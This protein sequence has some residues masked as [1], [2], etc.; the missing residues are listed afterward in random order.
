MTYC[1]VDRRHGRVYDDVSSRPGRWWCGH[2]AHGGNGRFFTTAEVEGG[3]ERTEEDMTLIYETAARDVVDGTIDLDMAVKKIASQ[4][5]ERTDRVRERLNTMATIV[6]DKRAAAAKRTATSKPK[7]KPARAERVKKEHVEPRE[8]A[9]VRD[10]LGL[11]N[12][13]V[14]AALAGVVGAGP[15]GPTASRITEL[16]HSKGSSI[17][18]F[19]L[20]EPALRRYAKAHPRPKETAK[21]SV[22][23]SGSNGTSRS[24]AATKAKPATAKPAARKAAVAARPAK[25]RVVVEEEEWEEEE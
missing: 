15:D 10:E 12:K 14:I 8:F 17:D 22:K 18:L 20:Y 5:Q 23:A 16:T 13:E 4:T 9:R 2:A 3:Y 19:N 25:R 1:P 11:S 6:K 21:A 24:K 7:A